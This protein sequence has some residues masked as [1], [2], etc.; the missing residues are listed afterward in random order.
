MGRRSSVFPREPRTISDECDQSGSGTRVA[1]T[2]WKLPAGVFRI[3]PRPIIIIGFVNTIIKISATFCGLA[4]FIVDVGNRRLCVDKRPFVDIFL[5]QISQFADIYLCSKLSSELT[6]EIL[7]FL[8][9]LNNAI[10]GTLTVSDFHS[11][12]MTRQTIFIDADSIDEAEQC[13]SIVTVS[14]FEGD[15]RDTELRR[16]LHVVSSLSI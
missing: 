7:Q 16:V 14:P 11:F 2:S 1:G 10:I 5:S 12:T 13:G 8:D 6:C 4:D 15:P 3:Q 9:P